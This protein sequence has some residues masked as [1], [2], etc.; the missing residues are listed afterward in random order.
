MSEDLEDQF[1]QGIEMKLTGAARRHVGL[2]FQPETKVDEE[3]TV[4][5]PQP[6][7]SEA[8]VAT[9]ADSESKNPRNLSNESLDCLFEVTTA[10]NLLA[11]QNC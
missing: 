7:E 5:E 8:T 1:N 2:G 4:E 9:A 10:H 6:S 11:L 3:P